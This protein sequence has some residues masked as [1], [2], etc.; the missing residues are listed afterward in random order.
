MKS[1]V[2]M[3]QPICEKCKRVAPIDEEMSTPQ[4]IVY[5]VKEPCT[6]GGAF[7]ARFMVEGRENG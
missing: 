5:R 7:K 3:M 1:P 2:D 4:W 6:C